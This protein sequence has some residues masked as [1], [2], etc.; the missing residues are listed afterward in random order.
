MQHGLMDSSDCW[1][2]NEE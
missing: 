2:M 1:I